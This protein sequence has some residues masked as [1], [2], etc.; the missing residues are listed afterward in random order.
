MSLLGR[1]IV[2]KFTTTSPIWR[3]YNVDKKINEEAYENFIYES[4]ISKIYT[5]DLNRKIIRKYDCIIN[6][7]TSYLKCE[8]ENDRVVEFMQI[9][10]NK[11]VHSCLLAASLAKKYLKK[12]GLF[13]LMGSENSEKKSHSK[14]IV[15]NISKENVKYFT[16]LLANNPNELPY[17]T[18]LIT[19]MM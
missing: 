10:N 8:L 14:F 7:T 2:N 19:L 18:K 6:A 15:D 5:P 13:V 16:K 1:K 3:V 11:D 17:N 4:D 9:A 12:N